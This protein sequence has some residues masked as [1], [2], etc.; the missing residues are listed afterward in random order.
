[1][2]TKL[3]LS[4]G[5]MKAGTTWL[6]HQLASHP[7]IFFTPEKE[8]HFFADPNG[9]DGPMTIQQRVE[10]FKR[11]I[12]NIDPNCINPRVRGNIAWYGRRYLAKTINPNWYR[13]LFTG[14]SEDQY[15]ADFSNLYCLLDPQQWK[16]VRDVGQKIRVVYTMRHPLERLWSHIKFQ[17]IYSGTEFVDEKASVKVWKDI[18]ERPAVIRY[19]DYEAALKNLTMNLHDHELLVLFFEDV[20]QDPKVALR[21]IESFLEIDNGEYSDEKLGAIVNPT[22]ASPIPKNLAKA[23]KAFHARQVRLVSE[24]G[25]EIPESWMSY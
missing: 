5:A 25:Y 13:N 21:M 20:H 11:V 15:A 8:V 22:S 18:L 24:L 16:L 14:I 12:S 1:M 7:E 4:V 9:I 17:S 10:R 23:A 2:I 6:H 19:G 3:F